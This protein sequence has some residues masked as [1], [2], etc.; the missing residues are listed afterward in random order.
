[1]YIPGSLSCGCDYI[2]DRP[3][4]MRSH[5]TGNPHV[6]LASGCMCGTAKTLVQFNTR[7]PYMCVLAPAMGRTLD[8]HRHTC[9][10]VCM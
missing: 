4:L 1:M 5:A 3:L 7:M 6:L 2:C 10:H 9:M 8:V